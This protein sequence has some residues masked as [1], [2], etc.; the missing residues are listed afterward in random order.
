VNLTDVAA[1]VV[2]A[3]ALLA[4]I[5]VSVSTR[6]IGLALVVALDLSMAAGVLRLSATGTWTALAATAV[7]LAVRKT[8]MWAV[9]SWK[10]GALA[11]D[12]GV[13]L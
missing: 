3:F 10:P 13:Q 9:R 5:A 4:G 1:A 8:V 7:I 12:Q 6:R 2:S 11:P